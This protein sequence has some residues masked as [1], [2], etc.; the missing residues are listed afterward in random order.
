MALRPNRGAIH[1]RGVR[2]RLLEIGLAVAF[3][4]SDDSV[5]PLNWGLD[6]SLTLSLA[7]LNF[8][9][10]LFLPWWRLAVNWYPSADTFPSHLQRGRLALVK[11]RRRLRSRTQKEEPL[12]RDRCKDMSP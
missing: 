4:Y 1:E 7:F 9:F 3:R 11:E 8:D 5:P 10:Y 12:P 6:P 2:S